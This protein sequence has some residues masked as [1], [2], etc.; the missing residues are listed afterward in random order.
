MWINITTGVKDNKI[1][2]I[3]CFNINKNKQSIWNVEK[4]IKERIRID[5][6]K[7]DL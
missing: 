6:S 7:K 4:V 3:K 2:K 5:L 1:I